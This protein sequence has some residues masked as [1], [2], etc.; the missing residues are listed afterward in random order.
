MFDLTL[1][2]YQLALI[3]VLE[4]L[5]IIPSA[6][7]SVKIDLYPQALDKLTYFC[8]I[9]VFFKSRFNGAQQ[10]HF[11]RCMMKISYEVKCTVGEQGVASL[12][13]RVLE[14]LQGWYCLPPGNEH[15][16]AEAD[17]E[18]KEV[19]FFK[20]GADPRSFQPV[21]IISFEEVMK[22]SPEELKNKLRQGD[23]LLF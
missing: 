3:F 19:G 16:Y 6:H 9:T 15:V 1:F 12:P 14:I 13:T 5:G 23:R 21:L 22:I 10:P 17:T 7:N 18:K 20:I 8:I 11:G 4:N 2:D